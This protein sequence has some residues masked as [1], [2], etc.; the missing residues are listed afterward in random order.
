MLESDR[1]HL[2]ALSDEMLTYRQ[3]PL[4]ISGTSATCIGCSIS[5]GMLVIILPKVRGIVVGPSCMFTCRMFIEYIRPPK[6]V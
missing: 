1:D 3:L 2:Y 5:M 6:S 4:V